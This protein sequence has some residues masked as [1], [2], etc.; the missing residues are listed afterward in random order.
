MLVA[1]WSEY[2]EGLWSEGLEFGMIVG[3]AAVILA[4]ALFQRADM[5]RPSNNPP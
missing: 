2:V 5:R 3:S 4:P 1:E